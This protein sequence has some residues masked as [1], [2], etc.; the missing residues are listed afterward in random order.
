MRTRKNKHSSN[1]LL[2]IVIIR[3]VICVIFLWLVAP[4]ALVAADGD[5]HTPS[6]QPTVDITRTLAVSRALTW[7]QTQQ[8][9]DGSFGGILGYYVTTNETMWAVAMAGI[10]PRT[11][12][13]ATSPSPIEYLATHTP[14]ETDELLW[15]TSSTA[16]MLMTAV[17]VGEAPM[18]FG[19]VD[20]V[21]RL[22]HDYYD[23]ETGAYGVEN[24]PLDQC[25]ATL[26]VASL[27]QDVPPAAIEKLKSY[28]AADGGWAWTI[29]AGS[30][31]DVTA[32]AIMSLIAAGEPLTSTVL[33]DAVTFMAS[34]QADS[35]GF[36]SDALITT[37]NTN[38]TAFALQAI[39]ALGQ[40]PTDPM[41]TKGDN[42]PLRFLLSLQTEEGYIAYSK[43]P[44]GQDK[45]LTTVQTVLA[46]LA[47]PLPF[48]DKLLFSNIVVQSN[49]STSTITVVASY[50]HDVN[51]DGSAAVRY[52]AVGGDWSNTEAMTKTA[53]AFIWEKSGLVPDTYEIEITADDPD[54][55]LFNT[56]I[57]TRTI[58]VR[59]DNPVS[60]A[61]AWLRTQ[62]QTDGSFRG[63][64]GP[65]VTTN[66][67]MW[68]LLFAG[69]DP[70]TWISATNQSP[71]DYLM[72]EVPTQTDELMWETSNTAQTLMTVVLAGE[73][74]TNFGG[75]NLVK[76]LTQ[77]YYDATTGT[78]GVEGKTLDQCWAMLAVAAVGKNVPAAAIQRL[79]EQQND[80]GGWAWSISAPPGSDTTALAI[81]ALIAA[82]EPLTSTVLQEATAFMASYQADSGG[83]ASDELLS[84]PNA[85]A[86]SWVVQAI[87]ALGQT[88]TAS[89]W[90]KDGNN[91]H[92]FLVSLQNDAGYIEYSETPS[93]QDVVLTTIQTIPALLGKPFPFTEKLLISDIAANF[94]I[95]SST[96]SVIAHYAH[97]TDDDSRAEISY[98][99]LASGESG[100]SNAEPMTKTEAAF[101]WSKSGLS[102]DAYEVNISYE[103]Y[104]GTLLNDAVQTRVIM[105]YSVYLPV[106]LKAQ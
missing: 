44:G 34:H 19:G 63:A 26:A 17:L 70:R 42:N 106:V 68:A 90:T 65:Y 95:D 9:L 89:Q 41:W 47:R 105:P 27:G 104:D 91:P 18:N 83:F 53:N 3:V 60:R 76:L 77:D 96:L 93:G 49:P 13:T 80:N 48:G 67:A 38:S 24:K 45:F 79:K 81:E 86:T 58:E 32:C 94:N 88:P 25:W 71:L 43:N 74:P 6:L 98:R 12:T 87:Y 23:A 75:V 30:G 78:Y 8:Q 52:R 14:T 59:E 92:D 40:S 22:T 51:A 35:G 20:L 21:T 54:G 61:L 5:K 39:Y 102:L 46:L 7:V 62:Q 10:D 4:V 69:E 99:A 84:I 72:T 29:S 1:N 33:Q 85:N 31:V 64:L 37:P 16:Q 56:A 50:A 36:G 57:Q 73:D 82:G 28:Q 103:D 66:E 11:W 100:W 2:G 101:I 55:T 15:E 97:D